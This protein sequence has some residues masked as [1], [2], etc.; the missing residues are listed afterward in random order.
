ME[1]VKRLVEAEVR[2]S[3]SFAGAV[4]IEGPRGVGKTST[5]TQLSRS[6]VRLDIDNQ[7]LE[8]ARIAPEMVLAGDVPRLVDEWQLAE[9]IWN[10]IRYQVDQRQAPGQFI[11]TGS[12]SKQ[13][14]G[15]RHP[16]T[17]R[18]ARVTMRPMT[19]FEQGISSGQV[20]LGELFQGAVPKTVCDFD[21]EAAILAICRGG[22]PA[23]VNLSAAA[24]QH[25]MR[26]YLDDV[27]NIDFTNLTGQA[28]NSQRLRNLLRTLARN[29]GSEI[30]TVK[31]ASEV[32]ASEGA[33]IKPQTLES[34]LEV[35]RQMFLV[36][37]LKPWSPHLRSSYVVRKSWKRYFVDPSLAVASIGAD[38]TSLLNDLE[39][40]GFLFENLALRDLRVYAQANG[41][42][43]SHYRDSGGLEVDAIVEKPNGAWGAIEVKL[44]PNSIEQA[45]ASLAKLVHQL[46]FTRA[47]KPAFLAV[48]TTGKYSYLRPDGV[49]VISLGAL[50]I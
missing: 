40:T 1:Y 8:L 46:D 26:S 13:A 17:G 35:L 7:A 14:L 22:F 49:S 6:Q 50:G 41:C 20:S 21:L 27:V 37:D 10:Q 28:R 45:A 39:T 23:A 24:S 36:D 19:L 32:G 12:A 16:G 18:V 4:L 43:V 3:L 48:L 33:A 5:G 34:Y 25:L 47:Q 30:A 31:I 38:Q 2:E 15:D 29:V 42:E 9:G 11:L 44:N